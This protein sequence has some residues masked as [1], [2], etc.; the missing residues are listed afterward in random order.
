MDYSEYQIFLNS[1]TDENFNFKTNKEYNS[2][3]EHVSKNHGQEYLDLIYNEF[4]NVITVSNILD[5]IEINDKYGEPYTYKFKYNDNN[6]ILPK[7]ILTYSN[8]VINCSPT[9]I[10]YIYHSLL[11][12][13]YYNEKNT[14]KIVEV[15][16]GYGGLF[17]AFCY[18]SK[19]LNIK[20]EKYYFVDLPEVGKLIKKY[21]DLN[22]NHATVEYEIKNAYDSGTDIINDELFFISNYCLTELPNNIR[23]KYINNFFSKPNKVI[24]GFICWQTV[25][26]LPIDNVNILQ[27]KIETIEEE[28]PQTASVEHKN[29][30]VYF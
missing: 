17:L 28:R 9:T 3:L 7:N 10:R 26:G 21:L 6:D 2:I 24:S 30:F 12:L 13:K 16:C 19:I 20:I 14:T 5:F 29:Y 8:N 23:Q 18:F 27:K 1:T 15:G 22:K 11:I 4:G 25:F